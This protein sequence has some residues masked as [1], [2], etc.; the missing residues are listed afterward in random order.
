MLRFGGNGRYV[1]RWQEVRAIGMAIFLP[2]HLCP[3][4]TQL[5]PA[6][7]QIAQH[8]SHCKALSQQSSMVTYQRPDPGQGELFQMNK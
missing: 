4:E 1:S 5:S 8:P 6:Q 7:N 2:H 3:P